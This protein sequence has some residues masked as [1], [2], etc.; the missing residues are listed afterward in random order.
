MKDEMLRESLLL[1]P[2]AF[3]T[4]FSKLD[5]VGNVLHNLGKPDGSLRQYGRQEDYLYEPFHRFEI[6][7]TDVVGE[8]LVFLHEQVSNIGLFINPDLWMYLGLEE[9]GKEFMQRLRILHDKLRFV[10]W[11]FGLTTA[12]FVGIKR[13]IEAGD[14]PYKSSAM[15]SDSSDPPFAVEWLDADQVIR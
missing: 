11:F 2:G 13:K 7:F 14:H 15:P 8:P 12:P 10:S 5:S 1:P 6:P 9:K 3:A 4:A